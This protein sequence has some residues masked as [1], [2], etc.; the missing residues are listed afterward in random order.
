PACKRMPY[1]LRKTY[2]FMIAST[3]LY[4]ING[5]IDYLVVKNMQLGLA[6]LS[7]AIGITLGIIAAGYAFKL[8]FRLKDAKRYYLGA[9]SAVMI[10]SYTMLLLFGYTRY[11]LASIYPLIGLSSLVFFLIDFA[12]YRK[13][14]RP[15]QVALLAIGVLFVVI[16]VF[17]A[18]SKG[19]SF[20]IGTLP[21]VFG[22][23]IIAGA[24][25]YTQFYKIKKYSI[26][27]KLVLQPVIFL[28]IA[29]FVTFY[30]GGASLNYAYFG[31]GLFGG[32]T[33]SFA[34]VFELRAMKLTKTRGIGRTVIT[35]N[36][37]NNFEYADTVLV[38]FGSVII[39]SYYPIELVGGALSCLA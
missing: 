1:M 26:G 25:Y 9:F 24:G 31:L 28:P 15:R 37:I 7:I 16:G 17:F 22:I 29:L 23:S 11:T 10:V 33:F 18:E 34:S 5:T 30:I 21:F 2:A 39:G 12:R 3:V 6:M 13:S 38:L 14:L 35:R 8:R 27:S 19:F 4:A 36:F 32:F 20:Q